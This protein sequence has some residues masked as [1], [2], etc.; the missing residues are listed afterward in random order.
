MINTLN[1]WP[2][3]YLYWPTNYTILIA[4]VGSVLTF[5]D[6]IIVPRLSH[7]VV[8]INTRLRRSAVTIVPRISF[9][10]LINEPLER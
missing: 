6:I 2:L 7:T 10:S 8:T 9:T 4:L 5:T 1:Y 3:T